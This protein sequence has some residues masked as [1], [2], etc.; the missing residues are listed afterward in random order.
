MKQLF[1][2]IGAIII[3]AILLLA[4]MGKLDAVIAIFQPGFTDDQIIRVDQ[5]IKDYYVKQMR[6]SPSAVEREQ[7]A[8]GSTTVDVR[9]IKVSNKRLEGF[10]KISLRDEQSKRLG[11]GEITVPCEATMGVNSDQWLWKCQK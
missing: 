7:I 1:I 10:V 9:M 11:L 8:S 6:A 3:A 4:Y 5:E 2:V